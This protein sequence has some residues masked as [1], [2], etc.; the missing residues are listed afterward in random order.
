MDP[1]DS[2]WLPEESAR[3]LFIFETLKQKI[4]RILVVQVSW[5]TQGQG[6]LADVEVDR[7]DLNPQFPT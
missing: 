2:P 7:L 3:L 4:S 5:G 1:E 6:N